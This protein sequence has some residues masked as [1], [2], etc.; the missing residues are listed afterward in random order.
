MKI[1]DVINKNGVKINTVVVDDDNNIM[2]TDFNLNEGDKIIE[3]CNNFNLLKPRWNGTEWIENA[4]EDEI[5]EHKFKV[6]NRIY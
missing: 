2:F 6:E 1:K 4:T 3:C 5:K